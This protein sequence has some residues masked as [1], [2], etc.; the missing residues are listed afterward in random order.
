MCVSRVGMAVGA[1]VS[2]APLKFNRGSRYSGPT[3]APSLRPRESL[4]RCA[5]SEL[6]TRILGL[7]AITAPQSWSLPVPALQS[8]RLKLVVQTSYRAEDDVKEASEARA[9]SA[10]QS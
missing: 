1:Q 6:S 7:G 10:A 3:D 8:V 9:L 4:Q 5:A 2:Q